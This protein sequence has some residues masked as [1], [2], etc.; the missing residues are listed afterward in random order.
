MF[1]QA[2]KPLGV[3]RAQ[4]WVLANLSRHQDEGMT[5][6]DLARLMDVSKVSIGGLLDR[7]EST[8][9]VERRPDAGDRRINRIFVL[10]RGH[11]VLDA[12]QAVGAVLNTQIL[13]GL[14]D[15]DVR[16][17]EKVLSRMKENLRD[18]LA[19]TPLAEFDD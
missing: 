13:H 14:G 5:Q 17:A 7:L 16:V 6:T 4:W 2:M 3:T 12:M 19:G 10:A 9:H 11:K 8:G 1:D 18:V 15:R